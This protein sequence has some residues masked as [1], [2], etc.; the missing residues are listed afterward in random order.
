MRNSSEADSDLRN[1]LADVEYSMRSGY[2]HGD[3]GALYEVCNMRAE[4]REGEPSFNAQFND[5]RV[6]GYATYY[7]LKL[8][9][10]VEDAV[11]RQYAVF[12]LK[13]KLD[14]LFRPAQ[15]KRGRISVRRSVR[16][17]VPPGYRKRSGLS[18]TTAP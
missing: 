17:A 14:R 8:M 18:G 15:L 16:G 2:L 7:A 10:A 4:L 9:S 11:G 3:Q 12:T 1:E 5:R 13:Q 6:A